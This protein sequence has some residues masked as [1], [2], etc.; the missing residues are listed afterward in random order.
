MLMIKT[1][2]CTRPASKKLPNLTNEQNSFDHV[3]EFVVILALSINKLIK[4][5]K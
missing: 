1:I 5:Y 4:M 2:M 3:N